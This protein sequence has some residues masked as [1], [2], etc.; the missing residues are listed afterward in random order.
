MLRSFEY[1]YKAYKKAILT[2]NMSAE[3]LESAVESFDMDDLKCCL[4]ASTM[5]DYVLA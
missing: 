3:P 1:K 4:T 2:T 5:S